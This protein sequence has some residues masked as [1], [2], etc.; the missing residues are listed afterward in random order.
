MQAVRSVSVVWGWKPQASKGEKMRDLQV[1]DFKRLLTQSESETEVWALLFF[2]YAA[3]SIAFLSSRFVVWWLHIRL[4]ECVCSQWASLSFN[5]SRLGWVSREDPDPLQRPS[6]QTY[7]HHPPAK[8]QTTSWTA[9]CRLVFLFWLMHS[10][11]P[12]AVLS[13]PLIDDTV[14]LWCLL[15]LWWLLYCHWYITN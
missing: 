6:Q 4:F 11:F 1:I 5:T 15:C 14:C 13:E 12:D 8:G 3:S 7:W 2:F 10:I 9:P